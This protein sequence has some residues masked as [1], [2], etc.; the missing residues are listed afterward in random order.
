MTVMLVFVFM[1]KMKTMIAGIII[2]IVLKATIAK[3]ELNSPLHVLSELT[4]IYLMR[5]TTHGA[6]LAVT[7]TILAMMMMKVTQFTLE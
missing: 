3:R 6:L 4:T 1:A 7:T 5:K 2:M